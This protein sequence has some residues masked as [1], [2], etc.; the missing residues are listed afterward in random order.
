MRVSWVF[1]WVM[2]TR[3]RQQEFLSAREKEWLRQLKLFDDTRNDPRNQ[4]ALHRLRVGIKKIKA[5][6]KLSKACAIK[7][8]VKDFQ[9]LENMFRQAGKIRDIGSQLH[10][11]E[12]HQ[13]AESEYRN[14]GKLILQSAAAEFSAQAK[15]YRRKGKK[16]GR[17]LL[18]DAE[19]IRTR[20]VRT[21]YAGQLIRTGILLDSSGDQLHKARKKIKTL[22]YVQKMLPDGM[23]AQLHLNTGYL[24]Q[25]QEAIG[26]W[27]DTMMATMAWADKVPS[28]QQ[29]MV[30]EC[31]EKEAAVRA[32]G[33]DFYL[34]AHRQ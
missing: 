5:F 28:A 15:E 24:D 8:P 27:H 7:G 9:L 25:L 16:A 21:W 32:L 31:Q 4:E 3:K 26:Q 13:P 33:N 10:F 22:L 19:S 6:V 2:L 11:L 14:Q 1:E 34:K 12:Q 29:G 17:H 30:R 18:A 20:C 23:A